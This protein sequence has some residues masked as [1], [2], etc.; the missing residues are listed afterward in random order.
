MN[1]IMICGK[2]RSGKDTLADFLIKNLEHNKPCKVQIGQYIK[3]YAMKYFGWD[4]EEETKPRDLLIHLGTDIIRNKI[5]PNFHINRLIEDLEVLSYFYDTFI[6]SDV[7][8]P[9][10]IEKVKEKYDNV[11]TIKIERESEELNESQKNNI[12][13]TALDNFNGYDF[14]INNNGTLE[15]LETK[16][17]NILKEAG[18][19]SERS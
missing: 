17:L 12:T 4:G 8:F 5:N 9:V 15:E 14:I 2:A 16:A 11:T 19:N 10:E 7:R 18:V 13:E 3:Y 1:I 6:V